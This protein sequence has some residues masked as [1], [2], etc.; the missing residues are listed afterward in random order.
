MP[1]DSLTILHLSDPQ[2]GMNH[3]FGTSAVGSET[4]LERLGA[5]LEEMKTE[6]DLKPDIVAVTGDLAEWGKEEEF[7]MAQTFLEGLAAKLGIAPEERH[8]IA[9]IPGNHDIDRLGAEEDYIRWKRRGSPKDIEPFGFTRWEYFA[10]L[11]DSFYAEVP[12]LR[13]GD[14]PGGAAELRPAFVNDR[15]FS[16]F[17]VPE[18]KVVLAGL[19]STLAECHLSSTE[20]KASNLPNRIPYGHLGYCGEDQINHFA[21]ALSPYQNAEWLRIG[22][23]HHNLNPAFQGD[24]EHLWHGDIVRLNNQLGPKISL[25]LHGHTHAK[26]EDS[27]KDGTP[28]FSTG[29]SSLGPEQRPLGE[30]NQYQL[31]KLTSDC[32]EVF[33]RAWSERKQCFVTDGSVGKASTAGRKSRKVVWDNALSTFPL[34]VVV[35]QDNIRHF[36]ERS[37]ELANKKERKRADF[38]EM[39][40][41]PRGSEVGWFSGH[42]PMLEDLEAICQLRYGSPSIA[43]R[44]EGA[45]PY[46]RITTRTPSNRVFIVGAL[47]EGLSEFGI[48]FF[49]QIHDSYALM[50]PHVENVLVYGGDA[51]SPEICAQARQ[52]GF[53][54]WS[55]H[56]FQR[57]ENLH[58]YV[59]N[60]KW[61]LQADRI[62]PPGLYVDQESQ[63]RKLNEA[64]L[65]GTGLKARQ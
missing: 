9:I 57:I 26:D 64:M 29:T 47:A 27:L 34:P 4:L 44:H 61:R 39:L 3:V 15:P 40:I 10:R 65:Y 23:I 50:D 51:A 18:F 25:L 13:R 46:L 11:F 22:L 16:L 6:F 43:P 30:A 49:K 62:Y 28:V 33:C 42:S 37:S 36:D 55:F 8:R 53:Q 52:A 63:F 20:A 24:E 60:Q 54:V 59:Q 31:L 12:D 5:D 35:T 32:V 48:R 45:V 56:E 58:D 41:G 19:N 7:K 17:I 1:G 21:N 38:Y 2:F 14:L